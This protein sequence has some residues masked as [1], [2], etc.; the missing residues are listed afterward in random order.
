MNYL[1]GVRGPLKAGILSFETAIELITDPS[2][3]DR[4]VKSR[5]LP[6]SGRFV[7]VLVP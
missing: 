2:S 6:W 5:L 7:G 3:R 4:F 1:V